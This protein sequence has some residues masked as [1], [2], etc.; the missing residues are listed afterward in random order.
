MY[1]AEGVEHV[2]GDVLGVDAVDG[3][4][5]V[6]AGRHDEAERDQ[7]HDGDA[8]VQSEH[9][10]VDVDVADLDE[11][12]EAPEDVEHGQAGARLCSISPALPATVILRY[13]H[14]LR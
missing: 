6:L 13:I 1:P 9:G 7:D 4:A 10:R 11:V 2:L 8:I 3:V 12:L 14:T 5:H